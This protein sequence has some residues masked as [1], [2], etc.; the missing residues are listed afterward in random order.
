MATS[1]SLKQGETRTSHGPIPHPLIMQPSLGT[2]NS[3][4]SRV[5]KDSTPFRRRILKC[6]NVGTGEYSPNLFLNMMNPYLVKL[7]SRWI[8]NEWMF[9]CFIILFIWK[10]IFDLEKTNQLAESSPNFSFAAVNL[11]PIVIE[12]KNRKL[13]VNLYLT[14]LFKVEQRWRLEVGRFRMPFDTCIKLKPCHHT[15]HISKTC[16]ICRRLLF[17]FVLMMCT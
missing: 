6:L 11:D 5:V 3:P 9:N 4:P 17:L 15:R 2:L 14:T 10:W 7:E 8:L 1:F 12:K 13:M 16:Y